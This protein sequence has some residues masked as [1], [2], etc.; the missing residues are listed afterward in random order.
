[1]IRLLIADDHQLFRQ[2]L[3]RL[4]S[5]YVEMIGVDE[6]ADVGE[7]MLAVRNQEIDVVI[8]DLTM[9]GRDG[10]E[11]IAHVKAQKPLVKVLVLTMCGDESVVLR[12]VQAGANGYMTKENAAEDIVRAIRRV[13]SGGKFVGSDM[14]ERVAWQLMRFGGPPH[15]SL[16][17][18]EMKIL[19]LLILGR[20]GADIAKELA[21]SPKTV[22]AHKANVLKKMNLNNRTELV[23]Y[24]IKHGLLAQPP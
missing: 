8:L 4:L 22:S 9:P 13:A 10:V 12:A 18:R 1:M 11:M 16:S 20:R 17:N 21:V 23:L 6:A 15:T 5:D 19:N 14:A 2:G 7:V 3:K 24:A